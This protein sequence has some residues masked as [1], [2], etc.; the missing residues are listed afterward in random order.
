MIAANKLDLPAFGKPI[1]P[2]SAIVF[3]WSQIQNSSPIDPFV[4]FFGAL[5]VDDLNLVF[6]KPGFPPIAAVNF[7]FSFLKSYIKVLLSSSNNCVPTGTFKHRSAPPF[8]VCFFPFPS[9]PLW[10]L[11]CCWYL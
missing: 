8:P 9:S 3:N 5:F 6:P 11:K 4:N 2:I 7:W 10:A 1:I